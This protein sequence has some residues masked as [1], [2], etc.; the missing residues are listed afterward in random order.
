MQTNNA[1]QALAAFV[2]C[3]M[4]VP[5]AAGALTSAQYDQ[6]KT[7]LQTDPLTLGYNIDPT[8][9]VQNNN[10]AALAPMLNAMGTGTAFQVDNV[11]TNAQLWGAIVSDEL[12]ALVTQQ[13][14]LLQI[15][16]QVPSY[17]LG[18]T[19]TKKKLG[20]IFPAGSVTR[21]NLQA[22][23]KR[24]GSRAEVLF[25]RGTTIRIADVACALR[26]AGCP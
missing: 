17:D 14:T 15:A 23:Q 2:V 7:E 22:L 4:L 20:D 18:V 9:Y 19:E 11:I 26:G 6:L 24:Q 1:F 12:T 21:S 5:W 16:L 10:D 3:L 8:Y 13:R 25:G